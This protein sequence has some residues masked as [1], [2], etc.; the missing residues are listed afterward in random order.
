MIV[1]YNSVNSIIV[2]YY[3][4]NNSGIQKYLINPNVNNLNFEI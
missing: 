1:E 2:K 3:L 4:V